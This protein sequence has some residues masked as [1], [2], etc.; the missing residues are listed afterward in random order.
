MEN[1]ESSIIVNS[2]N[3]INN[4]ENVSKNDNIKTEGEKIDNLIPLN[5]DLFRY[6][7][8]SNIKKNDNEDN[9]ENIDNKNYITSTN[10]DNNFSLTEKSFHLLKNEITCKHSINVISEESENDD[11]NSCTK[12][13]IQ[14]NND[15]LSINKNK[16]NVNNE[17][18]IKVENNENNENNENIQNM[19]SSI[20]D[21]LML[22]NEFSNDS[23]AHI[24]KEIS[25]NKSINDIESLNFETVSITDNRSI[26]TNSIYSINKGYISNTKYKNNYLIIKNNNNNKFYFFLL[27]KKKKIKIKIKYKLILT[28]NIII[29]QYYISY[30]IYI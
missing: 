13:Q 15:G 29:L 23:I 12:N 26:A 30:H 18:S 6:H 9:V 8:D 19:K 7:G 16:E 21:N 4:K 11:D 27:K 24:K 28:Y 3:I 20:N 1:N 25:L 17:K 22:K 14:N 5:D 10:D 2:N